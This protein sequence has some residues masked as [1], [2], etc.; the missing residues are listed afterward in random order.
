MENLHPKIVN[1]ILENGEIKREIKYELLRL[2]TLDNQELN[3]AEKLFF[4]NERRLL[5]DKRKEIIKKQIGRTNINGK[6]LNQISHKIQ[7]IIE[8]YSI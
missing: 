4:N 8:N 3:E 1:Y 6:I 5:V 2:K 7:I